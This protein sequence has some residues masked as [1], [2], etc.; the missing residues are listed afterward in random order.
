MLGWWFT[1]SEQKL[2]E[3]ERTEEP[4][5]PERSLHP[6]FLRATPSLMRK[7]KMRAC[8]RVLTLCPCL[9]DFDHIGQLLL[10]GR[11]AEMPEMRLCVSHILHC[12]CSYFR[13]TLWFSPQICPGPSR[14]TSTFARYVPG[15]W[16]E[17]G[18]SC[19][20][21]PAFHMQRSVAKQ[22]KYPP[23]SCQ[24]LLNSLFIDK[25]TDSSPFDSHSLIKD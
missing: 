3:P 1:S 19:T 18:A 15:T 24:S 10:S 2:K 5:A 11:A 7:R 13:F 12:S 9:T 14:W 4:R 17:P 21:N 23:T 25:S 20:A 6:S 22:S 8:A 16:T